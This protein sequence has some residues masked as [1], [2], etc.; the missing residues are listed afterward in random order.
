MIAFQTFYSHPVVFTCSVAELIAAVLAL[1]S[2]GTVIGGVALLYRHI[3][4]HQEGCRRIGKHPLGHLKLCG[5]HHPDVP[6]GGVDAAHI[7]ETHRRHH[8]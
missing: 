5:H 6:E 4:C 1:S 8:A 2:L 3:E 7:L